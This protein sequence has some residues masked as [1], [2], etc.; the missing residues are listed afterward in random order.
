M[1]KGNRKLTKTD[2]INERSIRIYLPSVKLKNEWT[3]H[4]EKKGM[5]LSKLIN[6]Y[7]T[8]GINKEKEENA[9]TKIN[10][11]GQNQQLDKENKE[12]Q[13]RIKMMESL[14]ER[15]E[16]EIRSR[17]VKPFLEKDFNG[18][19]AFEEDLIRLFKSLIEIRKEDLYKRLDVDV[20]NAD[21]IMAIKRQIEILEKYGLLQDQGGKWI[22]T[23]N[24]MKN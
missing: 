13:K 11:I 9:E 21:E 4:A 8:N 6:H 18:V 12:L 15:L 2:T 17:T 5:S 7:V 14:N 24:Q 19:R 16:K 23:G 3:D 22:W 10:L 1:K 20:K